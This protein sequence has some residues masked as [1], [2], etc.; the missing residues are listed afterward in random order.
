M[1]AKANCPLDPRGGISAAHLPVQPRHHPAFQTPVACFI[2]NKAPTFLSGL[3]DRI[4]W[5][6]GQANV[7][8]CREK[9]PVDTFRQKKSP[10]ISVGALCSHYLSSRAGQR[11]VL[12]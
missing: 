6:P 11:I 8:S 9:C 2:R 10:D 12:P 7:L 1:M 5:L 3:R 4:A